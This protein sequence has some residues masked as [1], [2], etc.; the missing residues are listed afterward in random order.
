MFDL[1]VENK[2]G[3]VLDLTKSKTYIIADIKGLN[4][5]NAVINTSTI[6]TTDGAIFNS[7]RAN[8][9]NIVIT[10]VFSGD[11]EESRTNLYRFFPIKEPITL[12]YA[13]AR[14]SVKIEGY[15]ESFECD[16]F[17]NS[18]R[19]Q[20]SILCPK[21]YFR[22]K[23][24][25]ELSF[26]QYVGAFEFPVNI[27]ASGLEVS[28]KIENSIAVIDYSGDTETGMIIKLYASGNVVRPVIRNNLTNETFVLEMELLSGD[29]VTIN[30]KRGEKSVTLYRDGTTTNIINKLV[31]GSTW[32]TVRT[33]SNVFSYECVYGEEN[34]T[35]HFTIDQL[36]A[37]V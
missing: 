24:D 27:P 10:V 8:I 32:L 19:A 5:P 14:R 31:P 18:Q 12:Y 34:I 4:P 9:R 6:A 21:S 13:N 11:V 15:V 25:L 33:G 29:I 7:S 36:F 1:S 23:E 16:L 28:S 20:I 22:S 37:G 26:S 30:T 3:E 17:Q 35:L 2:Y